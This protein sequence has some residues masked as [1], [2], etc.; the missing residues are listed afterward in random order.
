M[1]TDT[2]TAPTTTCPS[3]PHGTSALVWERKDGQLVC[4]GWQA[5]CPTCGETFDVTP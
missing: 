3:T 4:V 1:D 2:T 5:T